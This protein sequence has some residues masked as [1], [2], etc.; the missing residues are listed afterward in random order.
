MALE[1]AT[2]IPKTKNPPGGSKNIIIGLIKRE[3]TGNEKSEPA[4]SSSLIAPISVSTAVK[5]IPIPAPSSTLAS[6]GFF[7][8]GMLVAASNALAKKNGKKPVEHLGCES[9]PSKGVCGKNGER[10]AEVNE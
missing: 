2:K 9:C 5:P 3:V 1:A 8:F 6:G 4:P 7:V 10:E